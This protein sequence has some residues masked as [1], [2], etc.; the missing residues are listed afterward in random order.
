MKVKKAVSEGGHAGMGI[1]LTCAQ[2]P[3]QVG[4]PAA[5][6]PPAVLRATLHHAPRHT[7]TDKTCPRTRFVLAETLVQNGIAGA[8]VMPVL[9]LPPLKPTSPRE[10]CVP[11]YNI[12]SC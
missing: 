10:G 9:A 2:P 1:V 4:T 5:E 8:G 7:F 3:A 6:A 12:V 11:E